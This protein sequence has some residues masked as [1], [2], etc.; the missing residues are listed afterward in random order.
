MR[1]RGRKVKGGAA[2]SLRDHLVAQR[3]IK[4]RYRAQGLRAETEHV[5]RSGRHSWVYGR[6]L[7]QQQVAGQARIMD[8]PAAMM[9]AGAGAAD[10]AETRLVS[11]NLA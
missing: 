2:Q 1:E 6:A 4:F 8:F 9:Q 7:R 10:G 11:G 5:R 3:A